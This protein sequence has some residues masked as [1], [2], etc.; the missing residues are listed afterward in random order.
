MFNIREVLTRKDDYPPERMFKE[1]TN[2]KNVMVEGSKLGKEKYNQLLTRYYKRHR[3]GKQGVPRD[4]VLPK[5]RPLLGKDLNWNQL[6][7]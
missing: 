6:I 3:W 5:T 2:P 7:E 1:G 4:N